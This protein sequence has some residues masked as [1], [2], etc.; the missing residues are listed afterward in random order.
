MP[1]VAIVIGSEGGFSPEEADAASDAGLC[2]CGLG[3]R[4]LRTE[5][6]SGF[7]L[8]CLAYRFEL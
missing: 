4:I 3:R 8:S 5:T 2:L 7:V 6:A 1:T